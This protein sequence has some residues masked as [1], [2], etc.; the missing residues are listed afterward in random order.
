MQNDWNNLSSEM[1]E[2]MARSVSLSVRQAYLQ[3][4]AYISLE[5][6][7]LL[8]PATGEYKRLEELGRNLQIPQYA[9]ED[10]LEMVSN[11]GAEETCE[12]LE[13]LVSTL[14]DS[15]LADKVEWFYRVAADK[16][17]DAAKQEC[18]RIDE[19][20]IQ[21]EKQQTKDCIVILLFLSMPIW[22]II[23]FAINGFWNGI[24]YGA[25]GCLILSFV[26]IC[27]AEDSA[28]KDKSLVNTGAFISV[29]T[30]SFFI[31]V[32]GI[33]IKIIAWLFS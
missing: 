22:V 9:F 12:F 26:V 32:I 30:G 4:I 16:G 19:P 21:I 25:I 18:A 15:P 24:F 27:V 6:G 23:S 8:N 14:K 2:E 1:A 3:A 11:L 33:I 13:E 10:C 29:A 31:T 28:K 7:N 20:R 5:S 17:C